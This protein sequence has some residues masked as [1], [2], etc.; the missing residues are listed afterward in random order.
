VLPVA[1]RPCLVRD[2]VQTRLAY[3]QGVIELCVFDHCRG[4]CVCGGDAD[5]GLVGS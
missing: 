4:W 2:V 5:E 1:V 3:P